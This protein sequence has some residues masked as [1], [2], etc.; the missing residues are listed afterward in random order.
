MALDDAL[1]HLREWAVR[2][3]EEE[4][5]EYQEYDEDIAVAMRNNEALGQIG[6]SIGID[7]MGGLDA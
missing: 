1:I 6:M 5:E 3:V 7:L 2:V 4:L